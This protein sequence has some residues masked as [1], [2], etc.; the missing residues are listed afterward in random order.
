MSKLFCEKRKF[1]RLYMVLMIWNGSNRNKLHWCFTHLH[2]LIW[3]FK[4]FWCRNFCHKKSTCLDHSYLKYALE[5]N[6]FWN[7]SDG[8]AFLWLKQIQ[9][10]EYGLNDTIS[11]K[12]NNVYRYFTPLYPLIWIFKQSWCP[13]AFWNVF[14]TNTLVPWNHSCVKYALEHD[15]ITNQSTFLLLEYKDKKQKL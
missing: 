2:P 13:K 11:T 4:R 9:T 3:I 12:R 14:V 5:H 15:H 8:S 1:K 6:L 10:I 7:V